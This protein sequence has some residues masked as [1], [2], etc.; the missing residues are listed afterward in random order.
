MMDA[1]TKIDTVL[2]ASLNK[3]DNPNGAVTIISGR[4]AR[5]L[6]VDPVGGD[7]MAID[8]KCGKIGMIEKKIGQDEGDRCIRWA[9]GCANRALGGC[10]L[11]EV[12]CRFGTH[13]SV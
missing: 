8:N 5:S 10:L 9:K 2:V 3:I 4:T 6:H 13:G 7:F 11:Y 12:Q 1:L